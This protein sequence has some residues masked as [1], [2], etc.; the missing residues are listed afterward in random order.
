[1]RAR[2]IAD[3]VHR[4]QRLHEP[5]LV[6]CCAAPVHDARA[7]HAG[8][9]GNRPTLLVDRLHVAVNDEPE[10]R[11]AGWTRQLDLGHGP[12]VARRQ[13]ER[14]RGPQQPLLLVE[15]RLLVAGYGGE[16]DGF[17]QQR[18]ET[19]PVGARGGCARAGSGRE[20]ECGTHGRA[21]VPSS[22]QAGEG[23]LHDPELPR[24]TLRRPRRGEGGERRDRWRV[25]PRRPWPRGG[26]RYAW[27]G[28]S[29]K[30]SPGGRGPIARPGAAA[31]VAA[32][33]PARGG[34]REAEQAAAALPTARRPPGRRVFLRA[35]LR[36][37]T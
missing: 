2:Q 12:R 7:F 9:G 22:A 29:T 11:R 24:E 8:E 1:V 33:A 34:R 27:A 26:V 3:G 18:L 15:A 30:L 35:A 25:G 4:E 21:T 14:L 20:E 36:T 5:P 16:A 28:A 31:R 10:D 13:P 6:V 37:P 23:R 17:E 19:G 32:P